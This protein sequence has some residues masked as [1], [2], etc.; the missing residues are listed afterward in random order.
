MFLCRWEQLK[1]ERLS[2]TAL[3]ELGGRSRPSK[4]QAV[5]AHLRGEGH[6]TQPGG[7]SLPAG[8]QGGPAGLPQRRYYQQLRQV[9]AGSTNHSAPE[10]PCRGPGAA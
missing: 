10:L 1:S 8:L 4:S 9:C 7:G 5:S 2:G 3:T 6:A